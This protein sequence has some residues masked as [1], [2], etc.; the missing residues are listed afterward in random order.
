MG[1][2]KKWKPQYGVTHVARKDYN[3]SWCGKIIEKD[4][5]YY[6]ESANMR[7]HL[8]CWEAK[9]QG[10]A[11]AY[12]KLRERNHDPVRTLAYWFVTE[13]LGEKFSWNLHKRYLAEAKFYTNPKDDPITNE[14]QRSFTVKEIQDCLNAMR[15]GYFGTPLLN[16]RTIHAVTWKNRTGRTFL[17]AWLEIPVIPPAY[18]RMELQYWVN[19]YGDRA[20]EQEVIT[21]EELEMLKVIAFPDPLTH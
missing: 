6:Q 10:K 18:Q 7:Y 21:T 12:Q 15:G 2:P 11:S 13:F 16:I 4:I 5:E 9:N 19:Q 20:V 14:A 1:Y 3:C 17:E 8:E